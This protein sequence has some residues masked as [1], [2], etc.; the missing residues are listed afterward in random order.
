MLQ[1]IQKGLSPMHDREMQTLSTGEIHVI[2]FD[3]PTFDLF[4]AGIGREAGK[5]GGRNAGRQGGR[6]AWRQESREAGRQGGREAG[7]QE[8]MEDGRQGGRKAGR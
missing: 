4:E 8:C 1:Q 6:E 7:R 5:Q 2:R 3:I